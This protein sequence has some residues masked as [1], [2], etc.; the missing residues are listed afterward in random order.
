M[1]VV[2]VVKTGAAVTVVPMV[3]VVGTIAV[4]MAVVAIMVG[5]PSI[6]TSTVAGAMRMFQTNTMRPTTQQT[7][8]AIAAP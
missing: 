3:V 4:Q 2:V 5:V 1:M 6:L 8:V 7:Y